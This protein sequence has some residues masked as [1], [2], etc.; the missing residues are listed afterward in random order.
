MFYKIVEIFAFSKSLIDDFG[1]K[2]ENPSEFVSLSK[3][4]WFDL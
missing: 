4:P 2:L 1:P 3:K